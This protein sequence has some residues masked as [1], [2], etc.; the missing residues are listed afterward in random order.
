[1]SFMAV[2]AKGKVEGFMR[3]WKSASTFTR[4][5]ETRSKAQIAKLIASQINALKPVSAQVLGVSLAYYDSN[6]G[7]MQPVYRFT[8]QVDYGKSASRVEPPDFEVGYVG[9]GKRFEL[10]PAL[11]RTGAPPTNDNPGPGAPRSLP[12]KGA[13][14]SDPCV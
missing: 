7:F 8:A 6:R 12:R 5:K 3:N 10:I 14:P 1:M 2:G 11:G 9:I 13:G 4:V